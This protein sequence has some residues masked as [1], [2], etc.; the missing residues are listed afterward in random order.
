MQSLN[1]EL[2]NL[3]VGAGKDD[4]TEAERLQRLKHEQEMARFAAVR[5][6]AEHDCGVGNIQSV[7][8]DGYQCFTPSKN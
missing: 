2:L 8:Y 6:A 5:K 3:V 7:G 1:S 4:E